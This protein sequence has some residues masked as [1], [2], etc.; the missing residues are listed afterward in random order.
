MDPPRRY[1][2]NASST[3]ATYNGI[4]ISAPGR[5]GGVFALA[6]TAPA[7]VK[8]R[9]D[10]GWSVQVAGQDV[11]ASGQSLPSYAHALVGALAAVQKAL[12]VFSVRGTAD[13]LTVDTENQHIVG[14]DDSTG[15]VLRLVWTKVL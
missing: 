1:T 14:W 7:D 15:S 3:S 10:E 5:S 9:T 13:L 2:M 8:F 6:G 12:D 4:P 11:V